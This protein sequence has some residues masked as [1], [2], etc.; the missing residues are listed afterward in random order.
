MTGNGLRGVALFILSVLG[1]CHTATEQALADLRRATAAGQAESTE[2][3][4]IE[5]PARLW[6]ES[7]AELMDHPPARLAGR[8]EFRQL[9]ITSASGHPAPAVRAGALRT[10]YRLEQIAE[11]GVADPELR[12]VFVAG[13]AD[14]HDTV[15][16]AAAETSLDL[17]GSSMRRLFLP[18]LQR[19]AGTEIRRAALRALVPHAP[20][21]DREPGML[22]AVALCL[23]DLDPGVTYHACAVLARID[24]RDPE[25]DPG[26][27]REWRAWWSNRVRGA[28]DR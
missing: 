6:L 5:D 17:F 10:L 16:I 12:P 23:D 7:V 18:L 11:I 28:D 27:V 21:L 15:R 2:T 8:E 20:G 3:D 14:E 13:L 24:G 22:E 4:R 1:G 25:A 9:L 26:S 19:D